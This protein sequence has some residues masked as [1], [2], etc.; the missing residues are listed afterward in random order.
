MVTRLT[1]AALVSFEIWNLFRKNLYLCRNMKVCGPSFTPCYVTECCNMWE[2][3]SSA[4]VLFSLCL[5]LSHTGT[6]VQLS[7]Y[8]RKKGEQHCQ[9]ALG[10]QR[11]LCLDKPVVTTTARR[12]P[13]VCYCRLKTRLAGMPRI[14]ASSTPPCWSR[15]HERA[16]QVFGE[17]V[18]VVLF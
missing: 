14:T 4:G 9:W 12:L 2:T 18:C 3:C 17:K 15:Q 11:P 5:V 8:V 16:E 1:L 13:A 10:V 7:A 6:L